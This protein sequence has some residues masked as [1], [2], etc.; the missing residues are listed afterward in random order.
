M[1]ILRRHSGFTTNSSAASEWIDPESAPA[2]IP[3]DR[4]DAQGNRIPATPATPAPRGED[5]GPATISLDGAAVPTDDRVEEN[6]GP[7]SIDL[8][9]WKPTPRP[10]A[11]TAPT[12]PDTDRKPLATENTLMV[13]GFLGT[14]LGIFMVERLL[15]R[16]WR[17]KRRNLDDL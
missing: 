11:T 10:S 12:S 9:D 6:A 13:L 1:K 5:S 4:F 2:S 15:R 3:L 7:A 8:G 16:W 14:L 17:K